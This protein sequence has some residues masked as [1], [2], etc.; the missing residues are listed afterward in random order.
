MMKFFVSFCLIVI[1][2]SLVS[3]IATDELKW[4]VW[5]TFSVGVLNSVYI[6][7]GKE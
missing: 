3:Y 7:S 4:L 2:V 6:T 1:Y 5:A